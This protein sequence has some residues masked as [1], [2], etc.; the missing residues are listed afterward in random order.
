MGVDN[1][2]SLH[3]DNKKK[4]ILVLSEGPTETIRCYV[5]EKPKYSIDFT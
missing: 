1:S 2:S 5:I 4:D 3:V